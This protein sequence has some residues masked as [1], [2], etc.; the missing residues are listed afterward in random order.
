MKFTK[1][2]IAGLF[3]LTTLSTLLFSCQHEPDLV[4]GAA[5]VCFQND[6]LPVIVSHC[7]SSGCHESGGEAFAL[8]SYDQVV[9]HVKAGEPNAS[10][11][12]KVITSR[13]P[14]VQNMPPKG[15]EQ[16]SVVQI[17]NLEMW[18]LQGANPTTCTEECDSTH[19]TFSGTVLP[20]INTYCKGCHGGSNPSGGIALTDYATVTAS[21]NTG[22]FTGAIEHQPEFSVM[23]KNASKLSDC[24][25]AL[26]EKWINNGMPND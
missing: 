14:W 9:K 16:L 17:S 20:V 8:T 22:R 11:L 2:S 13:V 6:V 7:A 3:I 18:I 25:I 19:V 23:P 12:Y 21:V 4:P 15:H 1:R 5:E 24:K 26:I 10:Q